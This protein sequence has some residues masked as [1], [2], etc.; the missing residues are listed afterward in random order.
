MWFPVSRVGLLV[1]TRA[2]E[3]RVFSPFI[4]LP[5]FEGDSRIEVSTHVVMLARRTSTSDAILR[6][7]V[8]QGTSQ[9]VACE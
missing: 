9:I 3:N 7:S 5:R 1:F 2:E 4:Q 6:L 8:E